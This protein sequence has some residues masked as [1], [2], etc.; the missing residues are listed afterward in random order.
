MPKDKGYTK[1]AASKSAVRKGSARARQKMRDKIS[2]APLRGQFKTGGGDLRDRTNLQRD[3]PIT[4]KPVSKMRAAGPPTRGAIK[5]KAAPPAPGRKPLRLG[6]GPQLPKE[7]R[8]KV[9]ALADS[10]RG[11][12]PKTQPSKRKFSLKSVAERIFK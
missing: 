1:R 4:R 2:N 8:V 7:Q 9:R 5:R 3:V 11:R 10:V 12:Q 6:A